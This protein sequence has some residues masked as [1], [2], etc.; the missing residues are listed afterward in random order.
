MGEGQNR[1]VTL[2]HR[3]QVKRFAGELLRILKSRASKQI[4]ISE[5]PLAYEQVIEKPFNITNYGVCEI[6][7]L[8]SEVPENVI[9][10]SLILIFLISFLFY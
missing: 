6:E 8:I 9:V 3:T 7:D 10:V 4:S 2:T 5:F 1:Q